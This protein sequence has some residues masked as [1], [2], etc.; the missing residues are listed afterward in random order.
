MKVPHQSSLIE[1]TS[2][3]TKALQIPAPLGEASTQ[4]KWGSGRTDKSL[5]QRGANKAMVSNSFLAALESRKGS[6]G[7][8][9]LCSWYTACKKAKRG[10]LNWALKAHNPVSASSTFWSIGPRSDASA[11]KRANCKRRDRTG[12]TNFSNPSI[13]APHTFAW[14]FLLTRFLGW[15]LS[16]SQS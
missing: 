6:P 4:Y 11:D 2:L 3:P 14:G 16:P 10:L 8:P 5:M 9:G 1:E 13:S 7:P 15:A 12:P